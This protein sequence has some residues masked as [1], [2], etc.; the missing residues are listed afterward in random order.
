MGS[1]TYK[2][3]RRKKKSEELVWV[4]LLVSKLST[5]YTLLE[6]RISIVLSL[7]CTLLAHNYSHHSAF[8]ALH[9]VTT[10]VILRCQ[11]VTKK[12]P[13]QCDD[14]NI[15]VQTFSQMSKKQWIKKVQLREENRH[16]IKH[17][18]CV[19]KIVKIS[20]PVCKLK[21]TGI[22]MFNIFNNDILH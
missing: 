8:S 12:L 9:F 10:T 1:L 19:N 7:L 2:K 20:L 5:K 14:S 4:E 16:N 6:T 11:R 3:R 22:S 17:Q 15:I 13:G 21:S 18:I